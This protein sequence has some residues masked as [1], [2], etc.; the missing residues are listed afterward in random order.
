MGPRG[1]TQPRTL[2]KSS[3]EWIKLS[4]LNITT[5]LGGLIVVLSTVPTY[6]L[7]LFQH[8]KIGGMIDTSLNFQDFKWHKK[9]YPLWV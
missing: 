1:T 8:K 3:R 6:Q 2:C 9:I 5:P 4:K 7:F